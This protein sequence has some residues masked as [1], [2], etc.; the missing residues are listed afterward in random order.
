MSGCIISNTAVLA[1]DRY[2]IEED[3]LAVYEN[4]NTAFAI[5]FVAELGIK[6]TGL[7]IKTFFSD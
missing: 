4:I 2:P 1:L 7:G 3:K 5:L 6:L